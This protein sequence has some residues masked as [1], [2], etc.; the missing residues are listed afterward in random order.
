MAR[1]FAGHTH[2]TH[3]RQTLTM[4]L[5]SFLLLRPPSGGPR[6]PRSFGRIAF[7]RYFPGHLRVDRHEEL[8]APN[9][10]PMYILRRPQVDTRGYSNV[11]F[12][13]SNAAPAALGFPLR[14]FQSGTQGA[15]P[16]RRVG[17]TY[18]AWGQKNGGGPQ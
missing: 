8:R 13:Y 1:Y 16:A 14:G 10:G 18:S 7:G 15:A 9:T 12:V 11:A 2:I 6:L 17:P 4:V 5:L 3:V